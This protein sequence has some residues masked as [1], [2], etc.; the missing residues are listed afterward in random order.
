MAVVAPEE[1]RFARNTLIMAQAVH[2]SVQKLY[3]AG[4]KT[5][6]PMMISFAIGIIS[7]FDKHY[8]IQGF[9]KKSH[10]T[11]WD[12]I[13]NKDEKFFL[14]NAGDIFSEL[15]MENVNMFRDMFQLKDKQGQPVISQALKNQLWDL[16]HAMVKIS[17][18]YVH[19]QRK[20][21]SYMGQSG[22]TNAYSVN[23]S[24]DVDLARHSKLWG[25]VL[26][27]PPNC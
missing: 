17:I 23:F 4:Y 21:Y 26:E 2:E 15:P 10:K 7:S 14:E 5:V 22:M 18:K 13:K 24:D 27:F 8:L 6:N 25:V 1:E 19:K 3:D 20:P 9:I 16:F 12:S 11:S